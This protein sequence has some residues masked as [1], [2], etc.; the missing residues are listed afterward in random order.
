MAPDK[1][2]LLRLLL[3]ELNPLRTMVV[4]NLSE[5]F[6]RRCALEHLD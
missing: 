2:L 3:I 4:Q 1:L 5:R 6:R